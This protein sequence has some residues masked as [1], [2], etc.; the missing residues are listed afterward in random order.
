MAKLQ[1]TARVRVLVEVQL[2]D[3]WGSECTVEQIHKQA[4]DSVSS[5]LSRAFTEEQR[6]HGGN[7]IRICGELEPVA[8]LVSAAKD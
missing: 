1:G 2:A 4:M 5:R 6:A 8:V 3:T 7:R